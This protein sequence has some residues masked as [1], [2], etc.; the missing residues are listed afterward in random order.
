V[1]RYIVV[2]LLQT[3]VALWAVSII[4][5]ALARI[6]GNPLDTL[7]SFEATLEDRERVAAALGLDRPLYTQYFI[8]VGNVLRGEFGESFKWRLPASE[9]VFGRFPASLALAG[10]AIT[11][12]T[13][14]AVPLGVITAVKRDSVLDYGGKALALVGQAAPPFWLGLVLIW[15]FGVELGVVPTSGR[16]GWSSYVLPAVSLGLF[17]VAA[18]MRLIRSSMLD[19]L[20]SE[21]VKLARVKGLPEYKVIWKHTLRN[22]AIAPITYFG[23]ILGSLLVGSVSIETVF[24]WPG[25]GFLAFQAVLARDFPVIQTVVLLFSVVFI[26]TNLLID[27]LY[28]YLDPRI[29]YN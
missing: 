26:M 25:V 6:T 9:L 17:W 22:A 7:L 13:L 28:A 14:V 24:A 4:V 11:I 18:L 12:A 3:I 8:F 29:R 15:V 21:Y 1:Q 16:S 19:A 20:D 5:F 27:I 23:I 10:L 2:R